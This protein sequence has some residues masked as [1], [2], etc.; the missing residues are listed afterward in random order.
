MDIEA[1]IPLFELITR[2]SETVD[3]LSPMMA[4]HHMQ[5]AYIAY[6][7]AAELG[8]PV[9]RQND[10]LLAGALHD[11]GAFSIQERTDEFE[12]EIQAPH[13]H[14]RAGHCLLE[15]FPPFAQIA[16]LVRFHHVLW[17]SGA[18]SEFEGEAV[19]VDSH[20]LHLADRIAVQVNPQEAIIW[21]SQR[22][23]ERIAS[24]T[25]AM[26]VPELADMF[27]ELSLRDY[28][29]FDT[30]SRSL[31]AVLR[32]RVSFPMLEL[33]TDALFNLANLFR[34]MIDFRSRFTSTH[35]AGVAACATALANLAGFSEHE[36]RLMK[37]ASYFHDVG[38]LAIPQEIFEKTGRLSEHEYDLMRSHVY[39]TFRILEPIL[40]IDIIRT[41]GALHQEYL[42]GTGYPFRY[43]GP[44]LPAG[45][46]ILVVADVYTALIEDRPYRKGMS[47]REAI[48]MLQRLADDSKI[49]PDIVDLLRNNF[50]HINALCDE[51]QGAA[52]NDYLRFINAIGQ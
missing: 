2:I 24:Q 45:S 26:F 31:T 7:I 46:R 43:T 37:I 13:R 52:A 29:W 30:A 39:H 11:I 3:L 27:Q 5:V 47:P 14:A 10:L 8:L 40:D 12:F 32:Q 51:A 48:D 33:D 18:G 34:R 25:P 9:E 28:F 50:D 23:R 38:K 41:W 4:N 16:D 49:D 44:D 36:C 35:S 22:I 20:I 1:R 42:D 6:S 15:I 17:N 21:Q 19:P